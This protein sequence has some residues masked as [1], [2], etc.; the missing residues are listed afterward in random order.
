M[1]TIKKTP[2]S[3]DI[4]NTLGPQ[5]VGLKAPLATAKVCVTDNSV[6]TLYIEIRNKTCN[7]PTYTCE[8]KPS[9][10]SESVCVGGKRPNSNKTYL[11]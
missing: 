8:N 5:L 7:S 10:I 4:C 6:S 3:N 1:E 9:Y 2:G 11:F